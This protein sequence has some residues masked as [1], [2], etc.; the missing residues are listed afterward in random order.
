MYIKYDKEL[1]V[2]LDKKDYF[3]I[4]T[5]KENKA[6]ET[7]IREANIF[8]KEISPEDPKIE[9]IFRV[10]F[11]VSY[12]DDSETLKASGADGVW[13]VNE[14][15]P[16]YR[17]PKIENNELGLSLMYG[18]ICDEWTQDDKGSSSKIIDLYDCSD[19]T[20][21]YTYSF[22]DGKPLAEN[23]MIKIKMEPEDFKNEMLKYRRSNL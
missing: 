15:R 9:A 7:Y 22:K 18:S 6:D 20:V 1:Y 8:F 19:H 17:C 16:L 13:C 2:F 5:R 14:G 4:I 10:D 23:E 12:M 3:E 21:V 11:Y